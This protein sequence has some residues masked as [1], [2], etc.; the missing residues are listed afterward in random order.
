M[1]IPV[2]Q[3]ESEYANVDKSASKKWLYLLFEVIF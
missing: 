2:G 3:Y 1:I